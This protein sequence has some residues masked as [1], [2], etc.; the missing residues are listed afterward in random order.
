VTP[1]VVP[2]ASVIVKWV[3]ASSDEQDRNV[4]LALRDAWVEER[5]RLLVPSLWLFEVAS[6]VSRREPAS[7]AAIVGGLIALRLEEAAP[8]SFV[9]RAVALALDLGVT[10]H[11]AVYHAV[12]LTAGGVFVTADARYASKAVHLGAL[13]TL[14]E[15]TEP[16]GR[17]RR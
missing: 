12:A 6:V 5:I 16:S 7:A 17:T 13:C 14:R 1:L 2:D 3:L 10:F 8:R 11:D 4:A 15:W 9:G